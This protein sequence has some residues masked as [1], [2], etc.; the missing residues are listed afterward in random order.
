MR[1]FMIA[2]CFSLAVLVSGC[3][4]PNG[5]HNLAASMGTTV[6]GPFPLPPDF[7]FPEIESPKDEKSEFPV[8]PFLE[9]DGN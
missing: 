9:F 1:N 3:A 2:G 6:Q 5:L 8:D 7:E 4:T